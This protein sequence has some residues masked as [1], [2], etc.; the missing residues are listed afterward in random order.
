MK[1]T[2]TNGES[3]KAVREQVFLS[4]DRSEPGVVQSSVCKSSAYSHC[5]VA[6]N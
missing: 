3:A 6:K 5:S 4:R 1:Q 2:R